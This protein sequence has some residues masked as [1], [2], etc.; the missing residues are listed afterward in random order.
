ML[1][2]EHYELRAIVCEGDHAALEVEW[3]G[4]LKNG[5]ATKAFL[6][7]FIEIRDGTIFRQTNY[8]CF[9]D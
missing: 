4:T 7:I 9:E 1:A 6:G 2:S 8:D 3:S 5:N